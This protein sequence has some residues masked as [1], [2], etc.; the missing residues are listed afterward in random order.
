MFCQ[1]TVLLRA[2]ENHPEFRAASSQ[3]LVN[4]EMLGAPSA[5]PSGIDVE[6]GSGDVQFSGGERDGAQDVGGDDVEVTMATFGRR[7]VPFET[8]LPSVHY[9]IEQPE[10]GEI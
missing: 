9:H 7:R 10:Q 3:E 6:R 1:A 2:A 8:L 5:P 4:L